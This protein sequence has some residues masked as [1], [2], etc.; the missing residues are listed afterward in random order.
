MTR[1]SRPE[2]GRPSGE[3]SHRQ[4]TSSSTSPDVVRLA[5]GVLPDLEH[6]AGV[7]VDRLAAQCPLLRCHHVTEGRSAVACIAHPSAG[8]ICVACAERHTDRHA[9]QL[10]HRCD[11]CA[12]QVPALHSV[13]ATRNLVAI[14]S[15]TAGQKSLYGGPVLLVGRGVC[16]S[17]SAELDLPTEVAS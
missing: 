3:G 9:H 17:C 1:H 2:K 7:A 8:L 5:A 14:T 4:S 6:L 12:R 16:P 13:L 11:R 15:T 10:E